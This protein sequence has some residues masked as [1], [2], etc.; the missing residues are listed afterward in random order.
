[1]LDAFGS[2]RVSFPSRSWL[3]LTIWWEIQIRSGP[4]ETAIGN[5]A[6]CLCG[7]WKQVGLGRFYQGT[8]FFL[9]QR[10]HSQLSEKNDSTQYM[11]PRGFQ[12]HVINF[13]ARVMRPFAS[14]LEA[15]SLSSG[16]IFLRLASSCHSTWCI[17]WEI[18]IWFEVLAVG[19][20]VD[21]F[22]A[23]LIRHET[24][25]WGGGGQ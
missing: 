24:Y 7:I 10:L 9:F 22:H 13:L 1:M 5:N 18:S 12:W 16:I 25:L 6:F 14:C 3:E 2:G 19:C 23:L 15:K 4:S 21:Q 8:L 17:P 20:R 11:T